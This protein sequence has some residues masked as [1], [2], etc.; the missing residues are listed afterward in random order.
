MRRRT[1]ILLILIIVLVVGASYLV[2]W[3]KLGPGGKSSPVIS[4]QSKQAKGGMIIQL[5]P[6]AG[7]NITQDGLNTDSNII[8]QRITG[9]LNMAKNTS[10]AESGSQW[11]IIV[12]LSGYTGNQ[13]VAD[14]LS[15][16]GLIEFWD[17]GPSATG[18]ILPSNVTLDPAQY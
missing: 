12:N 8:Q 4:N 9:T 3:Y 5:I 7:Q 17:T 2:F 18:G 15:K 13:S 14:Q 10:V 16:T 6:V 11:S 1:L